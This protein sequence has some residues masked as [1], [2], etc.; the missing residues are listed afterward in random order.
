MLHLSLGPSVS[1]Y[2]CHSCVLLWSL[3][4]PPMPSL[5]SSVSQQ[6]A[7]SFCFLRSCLL[8]VVVGETSLLMGSMSA[9]L[10]PI[11]HFGLEAVKWSISRVGAQL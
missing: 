5:L 11:S 2:V 1:Q 7:G 10:G 3:L 8:P 6:T 9:G 4:S